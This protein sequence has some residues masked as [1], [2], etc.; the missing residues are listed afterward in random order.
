MWE[1]HAGMVG[2]TVVVVLGWG[3]AMPTYVKGYGVSRVGHDV[4]MRC[5]LGLG[6]CCEGVLR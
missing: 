6:L 2:A 5:K 3:D 4:V 1:G